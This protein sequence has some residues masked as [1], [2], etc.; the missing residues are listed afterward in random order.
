MFLSEYGMSAYTPDTMTLRL[1]KEELII[2]DPISLQVGQSMHKLYQQAHTPWEWHIPIMEPTQERGIACVSSPFDELAVDF[3]ESLNAPA[4]EIASFGCIDLPLIRKAA[5]TG[6]PLIS[7]TGLAT[8]PELDETLRT[9]REGGCNDIVLLKCTSTNPATPENSNLRTIPHLCDLFRGEVGLSDHTRGIGVGIA[10]IALGATVIE[11]NCTL[12]C[13]RG[14][15]AATG[16]WTAHLVSTT[17]SRTKACDLD[18]HHSGRIGGGRITP[19]PAAGAKQPG[20][21]AF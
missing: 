7:S 20:W 15:T 13:A 17:A 9:L 14:E 2:S 21:S 1:D 12:S 3:L 5:S 4:Y 11:K 8:L 19:F 6:K 10:A 18:S 16:S